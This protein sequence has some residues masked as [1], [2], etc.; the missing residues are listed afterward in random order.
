M[1]SRAL[2]DLLVARVRELAAR[3]PASSKEEHAQRVAQDRPRLLRCLGLDPLPPRTDLRAQVTGVLSRDGYRIE[4]VRYESRPGLLVTAHLYIPDGAGP[5]PVIMAP[6]GHFSYKKNEPQIQAQAISAALYGMATLVVDSPGVSWDAGPTNERQGM[7]KHDDALVA[8]G[9]PLYGIY[10]WDVMRGLDWLET[11]PE[12]D[13]KR[14]GISG[15]SG[16]AAAT[17]YAFAV[18][19]RIGSAVPVCGV[20]SFEDQHNN[21]CLCN[22]VPGILEL[23]DRADVL[24]LRAPAPVLVVGATDDPEFPPD[25]NRRTHQKLEA[26]YRHYQARDAVRLEIVDSPHEYNRRMREAM[27]GFF[28]QHLN[29]QPARPYAIEKRPLTD[30]LRYPAVAGTEDP[31]SPELQ[32][33]GWHERSTRTFREL[34]HEALL[35]PYPQPFDASA[36]LARWG[37]LGSLAGPRPGEELAIHDGDIAKPEVS[38]SWALPIADLDFRLAI[39]LGLSLPEFLAQVLHL[40]APGGSEGYEVIPESGN[41]LGNVLT[42]MRTVIGKPV[43]SKLVRVIAEGP[44]ASLTA[45]FLQKLRP[46]L[47]IQ[48]SHTHSGYNDLAAAEIVFPNARTLRWPFE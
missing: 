31:T 46:G 26:I 48:I 44:Y 12:I 14:V 33:T 1:D 45:R 42:S 5:F 10:V 34:L 8:M 28:D 38:S 37:K 18:D 2:N 30:G 11:R 15:C 27:L 39:Y 19:E 41:V 25:S 4:K 43:E 6:H 24:A 23:G 7:G 32:V 9:T 3:K 22:H 16:G 21:G 36:R 40:F 47:Q 29:G 13:T 35:A 17:M 20:G